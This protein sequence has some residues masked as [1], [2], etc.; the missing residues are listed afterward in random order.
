[1]RTVRSLFFALALLLCAG[2]PAGAD[3][4]GGLDQTLS[5]LLPELRDS[6]NSLTRRSG[7]TQKMV[8]EQHKKLA[9]LIQECN[10]LSVKLYSREQENTFDLSYALSKVTEQYQRFQSERMPFEEIIQNMEVEQERYNRLVFTLE[11]IEPDSLSV[12]VRDSC[13]SYAGEILAIYGQQLAQI[14]AD[15]DFYTRTDERLKD[16]YDY[17]QER[18]KNL[19]HKVFAKGQSSYFR[20]L[21]RFPR[22]VT[23][24]WAD[25]KQC[26]WRTP[27]ALL[28]TL[29]FLLV[30]LLVIVAS[31]LIRLERPAARKTFSAYLP[32]LILAVIIIFLR[33]VFAPNSVINLLFPP[34]V[35]GFCIWQIWM[36]G[37]SHKQ[38]VW[39]DRALLW[40]SAMVMVVSTLLSWKG[41]VMAALLLLVWWIFQLIFLAAL[42]ALR[43]LLTRYYGKYLQARELVYRRDNPDLQ[44]GKA[45]GACIEV[46]WL[47][48]LLKMTV[49]PL[50][51]IW[52]LPVAVFMACDVFDFSMVASDIFFG[53]LINVEG[54]LHLTLFKLMLVLSLYFVF[55]YI[56]YA[57]KAFY[58]V[59]RTRAAVQKLGGKV[60]FKETDVNF[61]LVNNIL[62]LL[63]WLVYVVLTFILLKIP[64]SALTIISTGL[65]TGIGFA[66]KDILNNFFYGIQLM[67]GRVRVG[68]MIECDG[69]RGTVAGLSYQSTQIEANDGSMIVFTNTALFNQNFKNL[70]RNHS[71]E[72]LSF[73][74]GVKY[75]TDVEKARE[76]IQEALQPLMTKDKYGRE[77]VEKKKGVLVRVADFGDSAVNLQVLLNT[78]VDTHFSFAAQAKEAIYKAFAQNGIEIPFPQQDVYIKEAPKG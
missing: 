7:A 38:L 72:K 64:T 67:G 74:V 24:A 9:A 54:Y 18:Y 68:D 5:E 71:Y 3:N 49:F 20:T 69:I 15:K 6:Y 61:N 19:Q 45:K 46:T 21:K 35:L 78:T 48:D 23:R 33:T 65:A 39:T 17:A 1:M 29:G 63:V 4:T 47:D 53:P 22:A 75:G 25:V 62:S 10:Q 26:A 11:Q 76:V 57:L 40:V 59:W 36:N 43:R 77:I 16:A 52:S 55:C 34:L 13:L 51:S 60:A 28:Y 30:L 37:H 70:T 2:L 42:M 31:L 58:R 27:V 8:A 56:S 14:D 41:L 50:L 32:T 73:T 12:P 44:L 66:M